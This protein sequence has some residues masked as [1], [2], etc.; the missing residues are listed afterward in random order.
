MAHV[1]PKYG[2]WDDS[3]SGQ[4]IYELIQRTHVPEDINSLRTVTHPIMR[5][6]DTVVATQTIDV[7]TIK[8][9]TT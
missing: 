1:K 2:N 6:V 7:E 3:L 9:D 8:I 5:T 4:Y